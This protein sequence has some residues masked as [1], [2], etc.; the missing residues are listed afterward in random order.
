MIVTM[1]IN[2]NSFFLNIWTT[3]WSPSIFWYLIIHHHDSFFFTCLCIIGLIDYICSGWSLQQEPMFFNLYINTVVFSLHHLL[4]IVSNLFNSL[5]NLVSQEP[6]KELRLLVIAKTIFSAFLCWLVGLP[7]I[8]IL[9]PKEA[10]LDY[11]GKFIFYPCLI[12]F[13]F[14]YMLTWLT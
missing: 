7:K 14:I 5:Y 2:F 1:M 13:F 3:F 6:W 4:S 10:L 9:R 11:A 8:P 12:L